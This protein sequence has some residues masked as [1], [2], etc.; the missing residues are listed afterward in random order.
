[1]NLPLPKMT[2]RPT[3]PAGSVPVRRGVAQPPLVTGGALG[4]GSRVVW[5]ARAVSGRL[6]TA[7]VQEFVASTVVSTL[8]AASKKGF[9]PLVSELAR[10]ATAA[11][12]RT[13]EEE[14]RRAKVEAFEAGVEVGRAE[15]WARAQAASRAG[16]EAATLF[17]RAAHYLRKRDQA[18]GAELANTLREYHGDDTAEL[19]TDVEDVSPRTVHSLSG[20]VQT[21]GLVKGQLAIQFRG[22]KGGPVV[23]V[24]PRGGGAAALE[25]L[26]QATS[27]GKWVHAH[28]YAS[29]YELGRY[30]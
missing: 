1:M 20:W 17:P 30:R 3:S 11:V 18:A 26:L 23:C 21:A 29:E 16:T 5:G 24:Y 22:G 14:L 2:G 12:M 25:S 27:A 8:Q 28:V 15:M 7:S 13:F 9:Q 6:K 19:T 4:G 10:V